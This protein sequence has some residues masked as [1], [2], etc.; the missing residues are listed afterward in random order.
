MK[1]KKIILIGPRSIGKTT[2]G[3]KLAERLNLKCYDFDSIVEEKLGNLD[4]Y[5]SQFGADKYREEEHEILVEFLKSM[6]N[7]F[8]MSVGGGTVASQLK[9][10]SSKNVD[11]LKT[12]GKLI[13]LCGSENDS[14]AIDIL[15]QREES[16]GGNQSEEETLK[17][18][19]LRTPIY[20]NIFDVKIIIETKKPDEIVEEIITEIN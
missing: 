16:R 13:Y 10:V 3:K 6:S 4:E 2:I 15:R 17:L 9:D 14:R 1:T 19:K 5:L 20:E 8:V 7:K 18:Y 12:I 11:L